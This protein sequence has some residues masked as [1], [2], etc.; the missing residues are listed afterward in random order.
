MAIAVPILSAWT[1][2][3]RR[4]S[5]STCAE[6]PSPLAVS[7]RGWNRHGGFKIIF[8]KKKLWS[9]S[10]TL[11]LTYENTPTRSSTRGTDVGGYMHKHEENGPL[12]SQGGTDGHRNDSATYKKKRHQSGFKIMSTPRWTT[13]QPCHMGIALARGASWTRLRR[14]MV[15][16]G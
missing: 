9:G 6:R 12:L 16:R 8:N 1:R 10:G 3:S 11:D 14:R 7:W 15:V 4:S 5:R 2:N 13:S